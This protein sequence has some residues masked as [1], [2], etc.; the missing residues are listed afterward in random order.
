MI[1]A[2]VEDIKLEFQDED[3]SDLVPE[4]II[5]RAAERM[6]ALVGT[7]L[8]IA[9]VRDS[10]TDIV[11][12]AMPNDHREAWVLRVK[13]QCC[14]FLRAQSAGRT[15]FTSGDKTMDRSKEATNWASLEKDIWA[16]YKALIGRLNPLGD[17]SILTLDVYPV[18]YERGFHH[19][20][21]IHNDGDCTCED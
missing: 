15:N 14:R 18:R 3:G 19:V 11:A 1:E 6:L 13:V 10:E 21:G 17:E 7:D 4:E 2:L 5:Y 8:G 20:V 12:P 16:E 9:Y